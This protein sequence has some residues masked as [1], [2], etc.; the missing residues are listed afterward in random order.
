MDAWMEGFGLSSE[1]PLRFA[2]VF[3]KS[4]YEFKTLRWAEIKETG[5]RLSSTSNCESSLLNDI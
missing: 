5:S 3:S 2:L 4:Q 1:S